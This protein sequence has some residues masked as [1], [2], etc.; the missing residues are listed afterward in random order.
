MPEVIIAGWMDY[1]VHRDEVLTHTLTV[2]A[3]TRA[4]PGCLDYVMSA[5]PVDPGRIQVFERWSSREALDRHLA[6]QHV[7]EFREA[8][9]DLPRTGRSLTRFVIESAESF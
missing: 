1:S 7:K 6:T 4:E 5:D 2:G 9:A 3:A 8:I